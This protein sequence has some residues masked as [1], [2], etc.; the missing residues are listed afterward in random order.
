MNLY[1]CLLTFKKDALTLK[2]AIGGKNN[3]TNLESEDRISTTSFTKI[4]IYYN[5]L[6]LLLLGDIY[7]KCHITF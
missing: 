5:I 2:N 3:V 7:Y 6:D 1:Y 4:R